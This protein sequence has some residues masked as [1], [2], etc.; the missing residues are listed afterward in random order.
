[1]IPRE[2]VAAH[3]VLEA[4]MQKELNV[5]INET[6]VREKVLFSCIGVNCVVIFPNRTGAKKVELPTEILHCAEARAKAI[7]IIKG[8]V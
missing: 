3:D 4:A 1:M 5:F 6:G 2:L 7:E 8:A